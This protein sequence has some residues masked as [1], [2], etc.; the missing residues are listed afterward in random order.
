MKVRR[1]NVEHCEAGDLTVTVE[2]DERGQITG[3][4]T[5]IQHGVGTFTADA[6]T[7][8][9]VAE[10]IRQRRLATGDFAHVCA[11]HGLFDTETEQGLARRCP[12]CVLEANG[13]P[14]ELS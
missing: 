14:K 2:F 10:V 12:A 1:Q 8:E 7:I 6:E 3:D 4:V 11:T 9:R 13:E 5:A